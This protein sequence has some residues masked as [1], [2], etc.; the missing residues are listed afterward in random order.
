MDANTNK[1]D[2]PLNLGSLEGHDMSPLSTPRAG[3]A[4]SSLSSSSALSSSSSSPSSASPEESAA[5]A[6]QEANLLM[7]PE[8]YV[9][10]VVRVCTRARLFVCV[11]EGVLARMH[12]CMR[13]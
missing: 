9:P 12:V 7:P 5:A 13:V 11:C 3:T 1:W 2:C 6:A 4:A 8:K 10:F